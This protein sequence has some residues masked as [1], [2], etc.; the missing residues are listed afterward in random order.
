MHPTVKPIALIAD[1]MQDCSRRRSIILD[2]FAGSGTTIMAAEQT[3]R[4]AYCMEID[5]IYA[6]VAIRR[7]QHGTGKDALLESDGRTF[8]ELV[9]TR[10]P[11]AAI[12]PRVQQGKNDDQ[13]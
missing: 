7:W 2:V 4:C 8:D 1:A 9:E 3:G 6:D 5:P 13:T 10:D 11:L 12:S